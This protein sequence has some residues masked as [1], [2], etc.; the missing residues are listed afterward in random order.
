MAPK[1][2]SA[3][4]RN[5]SP[6]EQVRRLQQRDFIGK[7]LAVLHRPTSSPQRDRGSREASCG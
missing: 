1:A 3:D 7:K 6:D 5:L 4:F 2:K